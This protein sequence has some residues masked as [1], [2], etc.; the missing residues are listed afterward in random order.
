MTAQLDQATLENEVQPEEETKKMVSV[1]HGVI[2]MRLGSRL[3]IYV[4]DHQLGF[5]PDASTTYNFNDGQRKRQPDV[6]FIACAK[7]PT[8]IEEESQVAPDLAVEVVSKNDTVYEVQAKVLQYQQAGVRLVWVLYPP[9]ETISIYRLAT[10]LISQTIGVN[11]E[12]DGED[13][14]PG[15]KLLVKPLFK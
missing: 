1:L 15:F 12:L 5:V 6:S 4:E 14:I 13:V 9:S 10:G 8:P 3:A 7:M 2:S 11:D